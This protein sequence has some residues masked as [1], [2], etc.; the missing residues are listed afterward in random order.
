M[1]RAREYAHVG[2]THSSRGEWR[3]NVDDRPEQEIAASAVLAAQWGMHDRA[4]Y[5]AGRAD[6]RR[7]ISL[8]FPLLHRTAVARESVAN[9]IDPAW[10]FGVM[11]RESAYISDVRSHAG[12]IGLMQLMPR[13][14][15]YVAGLKGQ[16]NWRGDLT[17]VRTNIAFGSF[18]LRHVLDEFDEHQA[19]ATASYNA[20]PSR[21]QQWKMPT[22][23]EADVWVDTIPFTETRRYV[24]AV[25]AYA[26]IY[27]WRLSGKAT[28]LST[29]M[30]LVPADAGT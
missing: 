29:M 25:L 30:P 22:A 8:R 15:S 12:A 2:L 7:A 17:D 14:A 13:T 16:A 21:V 9:R 10:V 1:I 24:R 27:Q 4:V 19:L 5:S 26:S 18:Y 11:R 6:R 20:G 28:R 23:M 3:S